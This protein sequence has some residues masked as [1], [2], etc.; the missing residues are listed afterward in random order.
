[1]EASSQESGQE[2]YWLPLFSVGK[3]ERGLG[4]RVW[5]S[6]VSNGA[7]GSGGWLAL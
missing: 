6:R 4:T 7:S 1:M 5:E 2:V 3:G